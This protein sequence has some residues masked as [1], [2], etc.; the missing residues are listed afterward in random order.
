MAI[1]VDSTG[2]KL[3]E[4]DG[5]EKPGVSL[6]FP[7]DELTINLESSGAEKQIEIFGRKHFE[8]TVASSGATGWIVAKRLVRDFKQV[9]PPPATIDNELFIA[10]SLSAAR[11]L[12]VNL[13]YLLAFADLR[14]KITDFR[15]EMSETGDSDER[16]IGPFAFSLSEWNENRTNDTHGI[17]FLERDLFDPYSQPY[18]A[19]SR[20]R[21]RIDN[22]RKLSG[23][24]SPTLS[25]LYFWELLPSLLFE[26]MFK[27][28]SQAILKD[29][30]TEAL[31]QDVS[32]GIESANTEE[33]VERDRELFFDSLNPRTIGGAKAIA[34]TRIAAALVD[35]RSLID[36]VPLDEFGDKAAKPGDSALSDGAA[37]DILM[38]WGENQFIDVYG[39]LVILMQRGLNSKL[40]PSPSLVEDL[41]WGKLTAAALNSWLESRQ[42]PASGTLTYGDWKELTGA[43]PPSLFDLCAQV[44][45]S[46]EGH[47]FSKAVSNVGTNDRSVL[48]WGYNGFT[49]A[50]GQIQEIIQNV[51][52][53]DSSILKD[54]LGDRAA[55]VRDMLKMTVD[56]QIEWAKSNMIDGTALKPDWVSFF[57]AFGENPIVQKAQIAHAKKQYWDEKASRQAIELG[58]LEPLSYALLYDIAIQNNGLQDAEMAAIK[59][60]M[61]KPK[62]QN[63]GEE[64]YRELI[65]R[66]LLDRDTIKTGGFIEAVRGRKR[67]LTTGVG[68]KSASEGKSY[69]LG[70]WGLQPELTIRESGIVDGPAD[71][72]NIGAF[73]AFEDFFAARVLE[74]EFIK[75]RHFLFKGGRQ[76]ASGNLNT[77]PPKDLWGNIAQVANLLKALTE[78]F[79]GPIT[80]NSVYRNEAYNR[81]IGGAAASRHMKFDAVDFAPP[82]GVTLTQAYN[83]LN[84]WRS[85]SSPRFKGGLRKYDTFIHVDT[86]GTNA[87]W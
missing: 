59:G 73:A 22:F 1:S 65:V 34:G 50:A 6:L 23:G 32:I 56:K 16:R 18:V 64:K 38:K 19:A 78:H 86:R 85:G 80:F 29:A 9:E 42:K 82:T 68:K 58:L 69:H 2:V 44:T 45:A 33:L 61:E 57:K 60:E 49:F 40:A 35:T 12:R 3:F 11:L 27:V 7:G 54:M 48:T 4:R 53:A 8:V 21:T 67:I 87:N 10:V 5:T 14:S 25:E 84:G 41:G 70:Y 83:L 15:S 71:L 17:N 47:G 13:H 30:V 20:M 28:D 46:F 74:S 31:R 37:T 36:Q 62:N 77:N 79:G 81:F 43:S 72:S 76:K 24:T 26:P 55:S 66:T 75:A 51:D 39:H 63:T 52:T